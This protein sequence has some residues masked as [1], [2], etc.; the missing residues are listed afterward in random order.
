LYVNQFCYNI[1]II[2]IKLIFPTL[3]LLFT[4]P[5][6][7]AGKQTPA[8]QTKIYLFDKNGLKITSFNPFND[9]QYRG[10]MDI[11]AADLGS[12][13]ISELIVGAGVG[14]P[15]TVSVFRQ[16]GTKITEFFAYG[17][18]FTGGV[19]VT[20][21]DI[22]NDSINEIITGANVGGGPHI[23]IFGNSGE[24]ISQFFA[25]NPNFRG[26]A[27][28]A[29]GDIDG[30]GNN[31][32][33]TGAGVGGGPH[34]RIF[35]K[36]G[37]L[38]NEFFAG[39][40]AQDSFGA[41][42]TLVDL[43]NDG[44]KEIIV[45]RAGFAT[46]VISIAQ[47]TE[48]DNF[49]INEITNVLPEIPFYK[50]GIDVFHYTKLDG[51]QIGIAMR[52]GNQSWFYI[53][54]DNNFNQNKFSFFND[55]RDRGLKIA[56]INDDPQNHIFVV[57]STEPQIT[58]NDSEQYIFID[59]NNQTL[60]AYQNHTLI[61]AFLISSGI[62]GYPTPTGTFSITDKLLWHDYSWYYGEND[63]RNYSLPDVKY[64][65]RFKPQYYLHYAYWHN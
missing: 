12:D 58:G 60:R 28:V 38:K 51:E 25:Y 41:R 48:S 2:K 49:V 46:P 52:G 53:G 15:P 65:L 1:Y 30:D 20:A 6:F 24:F 37:N 34:I 61:K 18:N 55:N 43:N 3:L 10:D 62:T 56:T 7:V 9:E 14:L 45:A 50:N 33:V 39:G 35:D 32:I 42:V 16:D 17:Q 47:K 13:N 31:E 21:C 54:D 57:A 29:C 19:N 5:L 4:V 23:R 36:D 63:P 59:L 11:Y 22:N 40:G 8:D 26:G 27:D 44:K 64:N